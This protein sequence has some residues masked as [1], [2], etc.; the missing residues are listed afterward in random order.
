MII[1]FLSV[2]SKSMYVISE[3]QDGYCSKAEDIHVFGEPE[4]VFS[5]I[6]VHVFFVFVHVLFSVY[7]FSVID[8]CILTYHSK[9][10]LLSHVNWVLNL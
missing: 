4:C 2:T 3:V 6:V 9:E 7:W 10:T 5:A 1:G 8:R